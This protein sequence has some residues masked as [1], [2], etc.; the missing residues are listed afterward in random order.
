VDRRTFVSG[1]AMALVGAPTSGRAQTM[2]RRPRV[3]VYATTPVWKDTI[4]ARLRELGWVEGTSVVVERRDPESDAAMETDLRQ[5]VRSPVQVFVMGGPLRIRAAMRATQTIPI[6]GIDLESDPVASGFVKS[7]ARPG[8]NVSGI[9]MDLPEL[10]GKQLQFLREV[11]PTL[12]RVGVVWDDRIGAPQ[13]ALAQS[14]AR[15]S[16]ISLHPVPLH[17]PAEA[18]DVMKRLLVERPEAVVLLTA[19]VVF[20]ALPR[21]A[22]LA[23]QHRLP[24]ISPFSTYPASGGLLAYGPDFPTMWRQTASYVDRVLKGAKIADLPVERPSKFVLGVNLK[25]AKALGLEIP[26]LVLARA[27]QIIE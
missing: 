4:V 24:S 6:V 19:P 21:L 3:V 9:W 23:R 11:I 14:A 5:W 8:T 10:A 12:R 17:A 16:N 18:A 27:D 1:L 15:A 2:G 20:S 22:D 13:L 25:A 26:P 7:L